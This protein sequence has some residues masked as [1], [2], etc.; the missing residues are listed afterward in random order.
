MTTGAL[1]FMIVG[2]E[3]HPLYEANLSYRLDASRED[4]SVVHLHQFVLYAALDPVD[5]IVWTTQNNYLRVV[6]RFNNLQVTCFTTA[7]HIRFLLLHEGKNEESMKTFF[8]EVYELYLRVMLNPFHSST[9]KITSKKFDEK[10]RQL[11]L[12]YLS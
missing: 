6:D 7:G 12:R 1:T 5:D 8:N 9:K 4:R 10:I 3:D 2:R 11:A